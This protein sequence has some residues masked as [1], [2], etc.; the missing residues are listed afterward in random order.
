MFANIIFEICLKFAMI[1][2][3]FAK[4]FA[5]SYHSFLDFSQFM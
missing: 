5:T 4:K 1:Q 3:D 2:L